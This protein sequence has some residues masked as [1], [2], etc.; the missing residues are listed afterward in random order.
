MTEQQD[1]ELARMWSAGK[2]MD[3]I[4]A[5]FSMTREAAYERICFLRR[6]GWR[7]PRQED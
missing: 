2:P 7:M 5:R 6:H 4:A 3:E 1:A